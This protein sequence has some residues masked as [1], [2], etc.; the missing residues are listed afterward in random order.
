MEE[1]CLSIFDKC[2][3][4]FLTGNV[5]FGSI[6]MTIHTKDGDNVVT[7]VRIYIARVD[8]KNAIQVCFNNT[9]PSKNAASNINMNGHT[10]IGRDD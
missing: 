10:Y 7:D 3:A 9:M 1:C 2:H 4:I 6:I 8:L 5:F